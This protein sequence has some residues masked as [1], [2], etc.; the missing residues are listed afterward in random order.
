MKSLTTRT[1]KLFVLSCVISIALILGLYWAINWGHHKLPK[2]ILEAGRDTT[3]TQKKS[4]KTCK[5]CHEKIFQAW[6]DGRHAL[7]WNSET[8]IE[9]SENRSKEKCLPCHIPEVVL[10]GEKPDSR[11]ENRDEGIFCFSCHVKS[12]VMRGPYDLFSPPHPTKQD[13]N[14]RKSLYCSSCH[15]KTYKEWVNSGSKETCQSCHMPRHRGRLVQKFPLHFLHTSKEV[16]DH[17]VPAG[18]ADENDLSLEARW[19]ENRLEITLENKGVPHGLPTADSG[20]P[21]LYLYLDAL[22]TDGK[23]LE[24]FKEILAPQ[25][26]TALQF[27]QRRGFNFML[28][29]EVYKI[30]I[31]IQIKQAW[32]KEKIELL[33]K[34]LIHP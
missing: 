24:Q 34:V 33:Q 13:L 19:L 5:N 26:E 14:Y 25:Q 2:W 17:S 4:A 11:I 12:E 31:S 6:K 16:A 30:A 15:V 23:T 10:A 22:S 20:D 27:M 1:Y 9:D 7:A 3:I 28:P 8:F 29:P 18:R 21:R 32:R